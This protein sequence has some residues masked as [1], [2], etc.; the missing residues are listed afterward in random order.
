M[1]SSMAIKI[2]LIFTL[3]VSCSLFNVRLSAHNNY[4]LTTNISEGSLQYAPT[5]T[6]NPEQR[7]PYGAVIPI[8]KR[9]SAKAT[10]EKFEE[11][12]DPPNWWVGFKDNTVEL[13]IHSPNI[14]SFKPSF[15]LKG[16][17]IVKTEAVENINYLFVKLQIGATATL[18][19]LNLSFKNGADSRDFIWN[20]SKKSVPTYNRNAGLDES[21]FI[22]LIMPDRF[23][24]ADTSNDSYADMNQKGVDRRKMFFRHGGDLKGIQNHLDYI[25][26]LGV[27]ALWL[28]PVQENN[29]VA[30]TYHGY[31]VTDWYKI[32]KRFGTLT[33]YN[34]LVNMLHQ[35]KM[36][37]VMDVIPNHSGNENYFIKD[38]PET[39]W[40]HQLDSFRH[41]NYR[42]QV[43]F[44]P[45]V[46]ASDLEQ[47]QNAWF[48]KTMPDMNP[49]GNSHLA[50][51]I[52]QN[53]LWWLEQTGLDAFRIDTY[54]YNDQKF[55][56][57][58]AAKLRS[59]YPKL[60]LFGENTVDN[61]LNLAYFSEKFPLTK[62]IN[63]HLQS[64]TDYSMYG[65]IKDA[66]TNTPSWTGGI[67]KLYSAIGQD[68]IYNDASK[69]V[70]FLDNHDQSRFYSIVK[71]DLNK[72]K[73]AIAY[74]LTTRGIPQWY[75]GAELGF[76]GYTDPD[77]KVRQDMPGGWA[78]DKTSVF[79]ETDR[80]PLQNEIYNYTAKLARWR[81]TK[82][83]LQTG[84]LTHYIPEDGLYVYFR[85]NDTGGAM[86][87]ING[88]DAA[89]TLSTKRFNEQ[90]KNYSSFS[91]FFN[92]QKIKNLSSL[93]VENRGVRIIELSK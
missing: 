51:Y 85:E 33:D 39:N 27:T 72:Y 18:G 44:D 86:I 57:E 74:L 38:L 21:D 35:Q 6:I 43:L 81:A 68:Y 4:E 16:V 12:I 11:R 52:I 19:D 60:F 92:N 29:Q 46:A 23:A 56:S 24:N 32:D 88:N 50:R 1:N 93:N 34:N 64:S 47:N 58:W 73:S 42:E 77:G 89:K 79:K 83:Y 20:L 37:M 63:S 48:D 91:D 54:F 10:A 61:S 87:V 82:S 41:P 45:H 8:P 62:K 13:M 36:K 76:K 9:I 78:E 22:Y 90:L 2:N 15:N 30:E 53:H 25:K 5:D 17:R 70:I 66:F 80:S 65:S 67:Q 59:E 84:K 75:Y 14:G 40:I 49:E 7:L 71:E 28:N 31:A 55:M 69:N 26:N 3:V